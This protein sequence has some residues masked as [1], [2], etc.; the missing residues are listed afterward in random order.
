MSISPR[1]EAAQRL[2]VGRELHSLKWTV[3][4]ETGFRPLSHQ[5]RRAGWSD[6][7]QLALREHFV[8]RRAESRT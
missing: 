3:V 1:V 6:D 5:E 8:T 2:R 7:S 4:K